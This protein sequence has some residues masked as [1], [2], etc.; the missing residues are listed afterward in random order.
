MGRLAE[1]WRWVC[2]LSRSGWSAVR[3]EDVC[4]ICPYRAQA[5]AI[6]RAMQVGREGH[7]PTPAHHH[8][9]DMQR[10]STH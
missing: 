7:T 1:W 8:I 4:V 6:T 5:S 3:P 9:I 10:H 2:V